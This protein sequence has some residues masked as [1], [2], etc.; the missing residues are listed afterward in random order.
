MPI[1]PVTRKKLDEMESVAPG[2]HQRTPTDARK[3][4]CAARSDVETNAYPPD[5]AVTDR[6]IPGPGGALPIRIYRPTS[7]G[8]LPVIVYFHGG[9]WVLGDLETVDPSC[10]EICRRVQCVVVSVDYRLSPEHK[11][12][13]GLEDAYAAVVWVSHNSETLETDPTR[14]A[15]GGESAGGN[16]A[17]AICAMAKDGEGPAI[18]YQLLN[19]PVTNHAF[20]TESYALAGKDYFLTTD[21]MKW[22]WEQYLATSEDGQNPLASVLL[23][24]DLSGLPRAA[25][26]VAEFDP[27]RDE[28]EA[29]AK[30]LEQANVPTAYECFDGLAHGFMSLSAASG[31]A[32]VAVHTVCSNL[33]A[34]FSSAK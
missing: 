20:D 25:V 33:A 16:L 30:R 12:P 8:R 3:M 15:V 32:E 17:A 14:I 34:A 11:F 19:Y 18:V 4:F 29:Y 28:G 6:T 27:L 22:F 10:V 26:Y 31:V 7:K 1:D 9:G 23:R 21:M 24:K 2:L 5:M 13:A